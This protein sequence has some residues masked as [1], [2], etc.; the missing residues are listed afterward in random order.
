MSIPY[1]DLIAELRDCQAAIR[2]LRLADGHAART[3]DESRFDRA[4][5]AICSHENRIACLLLVKA[6]DA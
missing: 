2:E 3:G 6:T 5:S 4:L 1:A